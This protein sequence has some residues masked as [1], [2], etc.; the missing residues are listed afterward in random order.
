VTQRVALRDDQRIDH[1]QQLLLRMNNDQDVTNALKLALAGAPAYRV[2]PGYEQTGALAISCFAVADEIEAQI[3]VRGTRWSQYGL[4]HVS[5]VQALGCQLAATNVFDDDDLL[6]LSDR[7]V[8]VLVCAY[9]PDI[10]EYA[11]LGKADRALLRAS[12][13]SQFTTV[14]RAFDPRR[15]VGENWPGQ[16]R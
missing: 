3:V 11:T 16:L 12:L 1:G 7:H 13:A 10:G 6:P 14:L 4:A 15:T 9:P 2:V 5:D 8:D